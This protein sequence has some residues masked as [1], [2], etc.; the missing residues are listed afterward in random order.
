ML[1]KMRRSSEYDMQLSP[2]GGN[3]SKMWHAIV[4]AFPDATLNSASTTVPLA[5]NAYIVILSPI[6]GNAFAS[7]NSNVGL[8][9]MTMGAFLILQSST[10]SQA[11]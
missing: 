2:P 3:F 9:N 8:S 10:P 4:I 11:S 5:T 1:W 7:Q 6:F